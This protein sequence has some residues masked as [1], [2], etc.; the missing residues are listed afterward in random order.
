MKDRIRV[1][2]QGFRPGYD[3]FDR[4]AFWSAAFGSRIDVWLK[5]VEHDMEKGGVY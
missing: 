4:L 3:L 5:L 1:F 2:M